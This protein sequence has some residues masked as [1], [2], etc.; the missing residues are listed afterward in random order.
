MGTRSRRHRE[1]LSGFRGGWLVGVTRG[2]RPRRWPRAGTS[3]VTVVATGGEAF[4]ASTTEWT[5]PLWSGRL[6]VGVDVKTPV[7]AS[8]K[9]AL[10]IAAGGAA[11]FVTVAGRGLG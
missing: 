11:S 7:A 6:L 4:V 9:E 2:R 1:G 8:G 3:Q 5:L 10:V